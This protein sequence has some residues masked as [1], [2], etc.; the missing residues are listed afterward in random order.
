F[1]RGVAGEQYAV[2][3]AVELL[4]NLRD[5][6]ADSNT[7]VL[8]AADPANL[9]GIITSEP[10]IPAIHTNTVA[11]RN[12]QM[13]AA[14][15][16][17]EIQWFAEVRPESIEELSR[18]LRLQHHEADARSDDVRPILTHGFGGAGSD[19]GGFAAAP[20]RWSW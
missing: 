14:C 17:R 12:G 18:K 3:E 13:I 1:V 15:Q 6:P 8:S 20:E 4:R 11:L 10:R 2:P 16:A 19:A 5:E 7:L 9:C